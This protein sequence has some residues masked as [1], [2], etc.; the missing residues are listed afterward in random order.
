MQY[1]SIDVFD[2][3][4]LPAGDWIIYESKG[5][6]DHNGIQPRL[7]VVDYIRVHPPAASKVSTV[8]NLG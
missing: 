1:D 4:T 6:P 5:E 8:K 7:E 2:K 3:S